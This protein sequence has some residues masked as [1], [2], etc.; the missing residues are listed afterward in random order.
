MPTWNVADFPAANC[1]GTTVMTIP[2]SS[3]V[4]AS[5]PADWLAAPAGGLPVACATPPLP[6]DRTANTTATGQRQ[7]HVPV[8]TDLNPETHG[9]C[10]NPEGEIKELLD[11]VSKGLTE[12]KDDE[13]K[14][15]EPDR[16]QRPRLPGAWSLFERKVAH[17]HP[18]Y[19][20]ARVIMPVAIPFIIP[21]RGIPIA[22]ILRTNGVLHR[23]PAGRVNPGWQGTAADQ[24]QCPSWPW[25]GCVFPWGAP[26]PAVAAAE[27]KWAGSASNCC[28]QAAEQKWY[29]TTEPRSQPPA[30]ARDTQNGRNLNRAS[31]TFHL[32]VQWFGQPTPSR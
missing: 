23:F 2:A 15:Q 10:Q 1:T 19:P 18:S 20:L 5:Q 6:T 12:P 26:V 13:V 29:R 8:K 14:Q 7:P 32:F 17:R 3:E 9:Q 21:L 11:R 4:W 28:L 31:P 24:Q 16:G 30:D 27:A 22:M 25:V